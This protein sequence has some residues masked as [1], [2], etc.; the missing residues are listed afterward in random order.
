LL[1]ARRPE[2]FLVDPFRCF[3]GPV[4]ILKGRRGI[5]KYRLHFVR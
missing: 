4:D 1:D 5:N 3:I 2:R